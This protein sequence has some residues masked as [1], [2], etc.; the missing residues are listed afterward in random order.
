MSTMLVVAVCAAISFGSAY[1]DQSECGG[2]CPLQLPTDSSAASVDQLGKDDVRILPVD[3]A[4]CPS[5]VKPGD[6]SS[7]GEQNA[8]DGQSSSDNQDGSQELVK[9]EDEGER[10][11]V[12][13]LRLSFSPVFGPRLSPIFGRPDLAVA[14]EPVSTVDVGSE[15]DFAFR[16]ATRHLALILNKCRQGKCSKSDLKVQRGELMEAMGI[17]HDFVPSER[18]P[19]AISRAVSLANFADFFAHQ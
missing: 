14:S 12:I 7:S 9:T 10:R 19:G 16:T 1:S 3:P 18:L 15:E 11:R 2:A 4:D 5:C 6:Q 8:T 17:M 13:G